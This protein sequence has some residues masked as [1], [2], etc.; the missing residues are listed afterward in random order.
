MS[1]DPENEFFADGITEDV[2]AHLSKIRSLKVISRTSV[3]P[4]K[5]REQSLRE[6]GATLDVGTLVEGSVR[7]AGSRVRIVAQLIEA[8]TDRHLW[9]ETYDRELT[10]IFAIQ[11]DVA[12]QIA[13]AL[14]A[15]LS[16]EEKRRIRKQPTED[17]EAYQLYLQAK[18]CLN[19]WTQEGVEQGIKHLEEA[20]ARD[21]QYALAYATMAYAYT[22][23]GIGVAGAL[24]PEEAFRRAKAAVARALELD[25][26]LAE[27]HASLGHLKFS[28]EYDWTAAEAE[29]KLALELN[30]NSGDA[31]DAYGLMLSALERYDEAVEMHRRAHEL[32]PLTYRLNVATSLL[33]AGR[34]NE[35]L[36][37]LIRL[38]DIE[39]HYALAHA[40]LGWVYV[41]T[42]KPDQGIASL[43][44]ALELSPDSTMYLA[45]L[46]QAFATVGRTDDA[47]DVL[48]RLQDLAKRRYVS[49]YHMAY[50][51]T[52]LGEH[53]RAIDWLER[54]YEERAGGVFGVKGSFL[55]TSLRGH[56]RFRGLL[57]KMNLA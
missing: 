24:P 13:A 41:L 32:D 44:K 28:G 8:K 26:N 56:P 48:R 5:K 18:H 57:R 14:E 52:G 4:F 45:Q 20:I 50:V 7:R 36:H 37:A 51:Y 55:F 47:R 2:I 3:M 1:T 35:A 6:I 30:P 22:G 10:D 11:T 34:H 49:P 29:L 17:V 21:P 46:G 15:E 33:R 27:A 43:Q 40:T 9:A 16:T 39:P 54:A 38:L 31:Y 19:R 23:I 12:L 53:D 42:G 25:P